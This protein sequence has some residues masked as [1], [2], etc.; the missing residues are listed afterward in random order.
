[1]TLLVVYMIWIFSKSWT[2]IT[3]L[4]DASGISSYGDLL[5]EFEDAV[6]KQRTKCMSG[7]GLTELNESRFRSRIEHR[8]TELEGW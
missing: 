2:N 6:V 7:S 8:L 5:M 3:E 1:M 4:Q